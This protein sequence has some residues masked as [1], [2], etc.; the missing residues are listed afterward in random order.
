MI[1]QWY[2]GHMAKTK[3]LMKEKLK[4]IDVVV[5]LLDARLPISSRNPDIAE[6]I[7]AKPVVIALN[8]SDLADENKTR[9]W[10]EWYGGQGVKVVPICCIDGKGINNL[11]RAITDV[12]A[13]K[14]A[15]DSARGMIGRAIKVM[16]VG[17]PNVGKSAFVNKLSGRA[18]AATGDRPGVTRDQQWIRIEGGYELLDTPGVLWPKF[19]DKQVALNLAFAGT[20]KEEIMDVEEIASG[21]CCFLRDE[22]KENFA[23]R[24]KLVGFEDKEGWEILEMIGRKRGFLISGGE[25]DLRR[26]ALILLDE[27]RAAKIGRVTLEVPDEINGA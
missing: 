24:Y 23:E 14:K 16:V 7:G 2:P 26:A 6:I 5:E 15:R 19:E 10:V 8:K 13:E 18:A 21:L 22:Y 4:L 20:I 11:K 17:V 12:L 27:F 9:Q 3:R 25:V 1:I